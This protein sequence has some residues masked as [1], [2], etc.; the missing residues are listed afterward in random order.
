MRAGG[1]DGKDGRTDGGYSQRHRRTAERLDS[2]VVYRHLGKVGAPLIDLITT[3]GS[4]RN[5][6]RIDI[7]QIDSEGEAV[8]QRSRRALCVHP[9]IES[10]DS[11]P[12][13][14]TLTE[15]VPLRGQRSSIECG[16]DV[17]HHRDFRSL[18]HV[19]HEDTTVGLCENSILEHRATE[20][21]R[22]P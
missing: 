7:G 10:N 12:A 4:C 19:H 5:G 22:R 17:R 11:K 1:D 21:E 18:G 14:D 2:L 16:A 6:S 15:P 8:C 13:S 9:L 20:T 3:G